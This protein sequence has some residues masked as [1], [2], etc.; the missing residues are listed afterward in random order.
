[1]DTTDEHLSKTTLERVWI[2]PTSS[3][4]QGSQ[5]Y[6]G[7]SEKNAIFDSKTTACNVSLTAIDCPLEHD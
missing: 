7:I 1:M 4:D 6:H 3:F 2:L 5:E